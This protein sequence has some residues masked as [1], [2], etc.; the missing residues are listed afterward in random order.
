MLMAV[1][2]FMFFDTNLI[3]FYLH[4]GSKE[5]DL[6]ATLNYG[7]FIAAIINFLIIAVVIFC[8]IKSINKFK[9]QQEEA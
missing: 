9:K 1:A 8:L 3:S 7:A 2:V 4:E 6:A 5:G